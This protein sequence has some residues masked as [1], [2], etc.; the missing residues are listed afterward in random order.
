MR[1][2]HFPVRVREL[3][4][5]E[6]EHGRDLWTEL[7]ANSDAD[8][9][10]MSWTWQ[11]AWCSH[12]VIPSGGAVRIAAA[13]T[14]S[15]RLIGLAPMRIGC[16]R[17]RGGVRIRRLSFLA[18]NSERVRGVLTEYL[19]LILRRGSED[20]A[21]SALV[22][23]C[24]GWPAWSDA[25][26]DLIRADSGTLRSFREFIPRRWLVR[27][28]SWGAM[29]SYQVATPT[30]GFD[31]YK[32]MLRQSV[33]K[34]MFNARARL[35]K[36]HGGGVLQYADSDH[37]ELFIDELNALHRVRWGRPA[38]SGERREFVVDMC[39]RK[40]AVGELAL[41]KLVIRGETRSV[42]LN[43]RASDVEYN[44]QS[45]FDPR[46]DKGLS[47][48]YLHLGYAIEAAFRNAGV[49]EFDLLAG[50]GKNTDYKALLATRAVP[51][52]TLQVVRHPVLRAAYTMWRLKSAFRR[53]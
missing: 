36:L 11:Q 46:F 1:S 15:G 25:W 13:Y 51:L 30:G 18:S 6:F 16:E 49:N 48:G 47:L 32:Q 9:L 44:L 3:S 31:V 2:K 22:G 27:E 17:L 42:L 41:S 37:I 28:P 40:A 50:A 12:F 45:G 7:L 52:E 34:T 14:D 26:L 20:S 19:G 39:R 38:F 35:V 33:R 43:M 23:A 10:F 21:G 8:P 29:V 53:E 5:E 24:L 4:P